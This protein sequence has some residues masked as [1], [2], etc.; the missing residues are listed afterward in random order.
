MS[1]DFVKL[2]QTFAADL[3]ATNPEHQKLAWMMV[4]WLIAEP[5]VRSAPLVARRLMRRP[6]PAQ[7]AP[8]VVSG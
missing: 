5:S 6:R 2:I 1:A 4:K 8:H 3:N 7:P